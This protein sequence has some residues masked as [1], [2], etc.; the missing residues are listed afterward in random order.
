MT[1]TRAIAIVGKSSTSFVEHVF[2]L[3]AEAELFAIVRDPGASLPPGL[4]FTRVIEP[5]DGA[6]WVRTQATDLAAGDQPAQITFTSGTEGAPKG[7]VLSQRALRDV[8]ER[9]NDIMQLDGSVREYVGVPP[10]YSFGLGRFRACAAVGG[11]AY[12]PASG[13]SPVEIATMLREKEINAISAV[14]TLWRTL[15]AASDLVADVAH[16]VRWIEIG[17]EY[18]SRAEKLQLRE[19]FPEA[20]IVQH[21]GLTEASRTTFLDISSAEENDLESVGRPTGSAEVRISDAGLIQIKGRHTASGVLTTEGIA[22][23][24]DADGWLTTGDRGR[25]DGEYLYFL[26]RADDVINCGGVKLAPETLERRLREGL[27]VAQGLAVGR[28]DDTLRGN[29]VV[30]CIE[31]EAQVTVDGVESE[32]RTQL[33]E[34]GLNVGSAL[35]VAEVEAIPRTETGKVRRSALADLVDRHATDEPPVATEV[36]PEGDSALAAQ[37]VSVWQRVLRQNEIDRSAS[38]YDQGGDSLSAIAMMV[39]LQRA[40]VDSSIAQ[41]VFDGA[42]IEEI[43]ATSASP[44]EASG[45]TRS[46]ERVAGD[47]INVMRG[48]LVLWVIAGHWLPGV[49]PRLGL[50]DLNDKL[51]SI[52]MIGT[53]GF[54]MV[55]GLGIGFF[56]FPQMTRGA[57]PWRRVRFSGAV[58]F[59]GMLLQALFWFGAWKI[60]GAGHSSAPWPTMLFYSVLAYYLLAIV[61]VPLWHKIVCRGPVPGVRALA[62]STVCMVL[63]FVLAR[64]IPNEQSEGILDL[65]RLLLAAGGFNYF[66][67]TSMVMLGIAIG[68]HC[69][70]ELGS[71]TLARTYCVSGACLAALGVLISIDLDAT[72]RWFIQHRTL[73]HL[74]SY[75]GL[76]LLGLGTCIVLSRKLPSRG[77]GRMI[78]RVLAAC[79]I[80][81]LVLFVGSELVVPVKDILV[82]LGLPYGV[83]LLVP[84]ALFFAG[85]AYAVRRVYRLYG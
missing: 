84:M 85:G 28:T 72:G 56:Y 14:P 58:V 65:G 48:V 64:V 82:A 37:L 46:D 81:S 16:R 31:P 50:A 45:S 53:P 55:F 63:Y 5:N 8:V 34:L 30:V 78:F 80:L 42:T 41:R 20:R 6:G 71:P 13:F 76:I 43:V 38:F 10:Y 47:S 36:A 15:L 44:A 2:S 11:K 29:G 51:H 33:A 7:M 54:A 1:A 17:S 77:I 23:I 66:Y 25:L 62:V 83:G 26:G 9:L 57:D 12:V 18:M 59:A 22:P 27:G 3:Y 4:E 68:L 35:H 19:V 32:A 69:R 75:A 52:Y 73:F 40:G 67:M 60:S 74:V 70:S 24:T 49:W 21:Y 79:G 39:S 61:S